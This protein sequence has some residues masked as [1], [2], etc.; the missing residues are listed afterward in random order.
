MQL[1]ADGTVGCTWWAHAS[2]VLEPGFLGLQWALSR[3]GAVTLGSPRCSQPLHLH[4]VMAPGPAEEGGRRIAPLLP[5]PAPVGL[6]SHWG[7]WAGLQV[8]I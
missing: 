5:M 2:S 8:F 4:P 3:P 7:P 6:F 1:P